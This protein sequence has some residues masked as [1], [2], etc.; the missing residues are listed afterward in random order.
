MPAP[1]D[2]GYRPWRD[3]VDRYLNLIEDAPILIGHSFGGSVLLK[4]LAEGTYTKPIR[5]LFLASVPYW[6]PEFPDF[7]LPDDFAQRLP[8]M[9]IFLYHSR[10]DPH[11]P[12]AH[13]T[14]FADRLPQA[15][16]HAIPGQNHSFTNGLPELIT[17]I[18]S[19][20]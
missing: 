15:T 20:E 6:G 8:P 11:V 13:L 19:L 2:P 18:R 1:G 14:R 10:D 12:F 5:G 3:A 17:D 7:A 16:L 4:Y 9:P